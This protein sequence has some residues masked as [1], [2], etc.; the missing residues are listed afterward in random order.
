MKILEKLSI[1]LDLTT[2]EI[3]FFE[4]DNNMNDYTFT[5]SI[6][7]FVIKE[8]PNKSLFDPDILLPENR[9]IFD[10]LVKKNQEDIIRR[11]SALEKQK[12]K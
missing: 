12:K 2:L 10:R 4:K 9:K 7:Q 8:S 6:Q 1:P 11:E 3:S 5:S